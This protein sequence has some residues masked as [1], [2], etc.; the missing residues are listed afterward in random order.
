MA[1][2]L[3]LAVLPT[4]WL[5]WTGDAADIIRI[6]I[7]PLAGVGSRVA[8]A[9]RPVNVQRGAAGNVEDLLHVEG[10][11]DRLERLLLQ[12]Q[13]R[14]AEMEAQLRHI[15]GLPPRTS[16]SQP[17][18]LI[19]LDV[20][21]RRPDH[22]VSGVELHVPAESTGRV[23]VGD[24]LTWDG[25]W[26]IGRIT[27]VSDIRL[28]A[29]PIT[30]PD[31]G[32]LMGVLLPEGVKA[33]AASA[34]AVRLRQ[35]GRGQLL[36]EIDRRTDAKIGDRIVLADRAWPV[37]LQAFRIGRVTAVEDLDEAPLRRRLV[38][39]PE[40]HLYELPWVVVVGPDGPDGV[41]Q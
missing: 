11:R 31:V 8:G 30:H 16:S 14:S 12:E 10:Q 36:G 41:V 5:G 35:N 26:L 1:L 4:R 6:P 27:R 40:V 28:S 25:R 2:T 7:M 24:A 29:L 39:E 34:P 38:V 3:L 22:P 23:Q 13:L 33:N 9:M 18:L 17:P 20:T 32:P 37:S 19:E 15:Q 21:G